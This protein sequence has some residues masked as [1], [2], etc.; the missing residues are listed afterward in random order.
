MA[1]TLHGDLCKFRSISRSFL[2]RLRNVSDKR[3][4]ENRNTLSYSVTLFQ[5]SYRLRD[6]VE[7]YCRARQPTGDNISL[8]LCMLDT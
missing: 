4:T 8:A 6:N 3:Y 1:G 2:L 7:K 5:K